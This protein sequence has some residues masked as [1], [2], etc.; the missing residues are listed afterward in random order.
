MI[1][2]DDFIAGAS[3]ISGFLG[4]QDTNDTNQAISAENNATSIE[5]ANT[6]HTR[7]VADLKNAGLNP[8]LSYFGKGAAVPNFSTP[9]I[10]NPVTPAVHSMN[11]SKLASAQAAQLAAQTDTAVT[12]AALNGSLAQKAQAE[13]V[14]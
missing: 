14:Y 5:L 7:E 9:N 1:G 6:A 2:F 10:Q 4:G 13:T 8:M 3:L 11:E 12:Q